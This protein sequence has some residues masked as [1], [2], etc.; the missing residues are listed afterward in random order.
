M[1]HSNENLLIKKHQKLVLSIV[2]SF[3]PKKSEIDDYIQ[4]GNIGLLYA[5]RKH[6]PSKGKLTTIAVPSIKWE[7][8]KYI[9]KNKKYYHEFTNYNIDAEDYRNSLYKDILDYTY[10]ILDKLEQKILFL[11]TSGMTFKEISDQTGLTINKITK[12]Y[13]T[14]INKIKEAYQ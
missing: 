6:I 12:I 1:F 13:Y 5:I 7:I 11:K 9:T 8:I 10:E 2:K 4:H 3:N 14:I